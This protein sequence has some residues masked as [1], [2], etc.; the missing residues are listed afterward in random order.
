M[1][2]LMG[3]I[4]DRKARV[5]AAVAAAVIAASAVA[6]ALSEEIGIIVWA[7]SGVLGLAYGLAMVWSIR[8]P[9]PARPAAVQADAATLAASAIAAAERVLAEAAP[10]APSRQEP[11]APA[12]RS[13]GFAP[14][15]GSA[16]VGAHPA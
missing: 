13:G 15:V 1:G 16:G 14:V 2:A 5:S 6:A 8:K 9:A 10:S 3:E 11:A 4:L 12:L 7:G